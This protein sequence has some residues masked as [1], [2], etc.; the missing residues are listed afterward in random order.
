MPVAPVE[1][2]RFARLVR[3]QQIMRRGATGAAYLPADRAMTDQKKR[4]RSIDRERIALGEEHEVRHWTQRLGISE[5]RLRAAV[6][7]VGNIAYDVRA[8]LLS[9]REDKEPD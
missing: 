8:Y 9:G 3:A 2:S 5:E 1:A 4:G 6:G 7:K